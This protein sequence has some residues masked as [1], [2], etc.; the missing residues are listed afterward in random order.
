[1]FRLKD[2]PFAKTPGVERPVV[3]AAM[4]PLKQELE[5]TVAS[6]LMTSP[7][8][9]IINY[10][11]WGAG[12]THA[13]RYFL[14]KDTLKAIAKE[15]KTKTAFGIPI[16]C[17]RKEVLDSLY[18]SIVD[19]I[20][21]DN[22]RNLIE[23]VVF[24]KGTIVEKDDQINCLEKVGF[25]YGIARVFQGLLS[26]DLETRNSAERYLYLAAATSDL[27][28]LQVPGT[29]RL[30]GDLFQVLSQIIRLLVV[31]SSLFSRVFLWIDEM[32][33][34]ETLSGKELGDARSFL[35]TLI[36]LVP[37]NLTMFLNVTKK[38][39]ELD[40]FFT[41]LG[42]AVLERVSTM[43]EF[44]E[45]SN[46]DAIAYVHDLLNSEVYR[47]PKDKKIL[48][49]SGLSFF[50]FNE[51]GI[52]EAY[53]LLTSHLKRKPTPRNINDV[54]SGSLDMALRDTSLVKDLS[55]LHKT[56]D[57]KFMKENWDFVK[58]GIYVPA[59]I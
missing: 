49:E 32:E 26:K 29:I 39:A 59:V 6:C 50:P 36:D 2:S 5:K 11:E 25:G 31:G 57:D 37:Q 9:I 38:R 19:S 48:E 51:T 27:K 20:G 16:V 4:A 10:G 43:I 30:A 54:I 47:R 33:T 52:S 28:I 45:M 35:R 14:R 18:L 58:T 8:R 56:I 17:P 46:E 21:L 55:A 44:P 12:K 15:V 22:I 13:M 40:S 42:S 1:V 24:A 3:W 34:I 41:F 53:R 7:S 23:R